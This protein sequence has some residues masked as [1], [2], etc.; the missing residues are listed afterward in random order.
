MRLDRWQIIQRDIW[1]SNVLV[2][3]FLPNVTINIQTLQENNW[4]GFLQLTCCSHDTQTLLQYYGPFVNWIRPQWAINGTFSLFLSGTS[5]QVASV[6]GTMTLMW[7]YCNN[8]YQT[9]FNH[10]PNCSRKVYRIPMETA[11]RMGIS[12]FLKMQLTHIT[13]V[14]WN[15]KQSCFIRNVDAS[16]RTCQVM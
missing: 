15:V 7:R 8:D 14:G 13:G 9:E 6:W 11:R 16:S 1:I 2:V 12:V 4:I 5:C 10:I 3:Y